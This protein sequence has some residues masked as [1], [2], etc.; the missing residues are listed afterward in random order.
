MEL[1]TFSD[2]EAIQRHYHDFFMEHYHERLIP[3]LSLSDL[4]NPYF[5]KSLVLFQAQQPI[6]LCSLFKNADLTYENEPVLCFGY[7]ECVNDKNIAQKFIQS[8][9]IEAK[10][11]NIKQLIGPLNGSTWHDYRFAE[12]FKQNLFFTERFHLPYYNTLL[13]E[14]GFEKIASYVSKKDAKL[15][16]LPSKKMTQI[17]AFWKDKNLKIRNLDPNNYEKEI[18][19]IHDFTLDAFANNF[20]YTPITKDT[21]LKKYLPIKPY[22]DF[23]LIFLAELNDELLGIIFTI[24][25]AYNKNQLIVKTIAKKPGKISAGVTHI[26]GQKLVETARKKGYTSMI[27]AFMH[28]DNASA[29]VSSIFSGETYRS[30][31]LLKKQVL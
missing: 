4:Q 24:P 10:K 14:M 30:Y 29:N 15:A 9:Y 25:D 18:R 20:L 23:D 5:L 12:D 2:I 1:R 19:K 27:H 21:F 26:L 11:L 16:A 31:V 22:L 13:H 6:A 17:E 8:L 3:N 28:E 7:F